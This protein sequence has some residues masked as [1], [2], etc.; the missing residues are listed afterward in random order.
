MRFFV[1]IDEKF[2]SFIALLS[3]SDPRQNF[4]FSHSI[5][6]FYVHLQVHMFCVIILNSFSRIA[7]VGKYRT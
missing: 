4:F 6:K 7:L 3:F 1:I 2:N 5:P